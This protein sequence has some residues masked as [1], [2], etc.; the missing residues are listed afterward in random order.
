MQTQ[1]ATITSEESKRMQQRI[2][3]NMQHLQKHLSQWEISK[4]ETYL[5]PSRTK[6]SCRTIKQRKKWK[7]TDCVLMLQ[8]HVK[9]NYF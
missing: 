8:L 6:N 1:S 7:T 3:T 5:P 2:A 9:W 4:Q